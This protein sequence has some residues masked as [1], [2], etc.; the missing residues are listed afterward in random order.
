M[1]NYA[2]LSKSESQHLIRHHLSDLGHREAL[3]ILKAQYQDLTDAE[4]GKAIR[5][6]VS[7]VPLTDGDV[8]LGFRDFM[9]SAQD[10]APA[11]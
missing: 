7:R 8:G 3:E 2:E 5:S 4:L 6:W 10:Q 9:E 11:Q 1:M